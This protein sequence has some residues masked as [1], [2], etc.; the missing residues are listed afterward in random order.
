MDV[1]V[2]P[3]AFPDYALK[4]PNS[5]GWRG[6]VTST[7]SIQKQIMVFGHWFRLGDND[8]VL[9]ISQ[10]TPYPHTETNN[11]CKRARLDA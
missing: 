6:M 4:K 2:R 8:C 11:Q 9:P 10:L 7:R 3:F 1:C 5:I